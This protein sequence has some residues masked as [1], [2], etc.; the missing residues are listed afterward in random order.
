[1]TSELEE[2]CKGG[3][4]VSSHTPELDKALFRNSNKQVYPSLVQ[5][6]VQALVITPVSCQVKSP[7]VKVSPSLVLTLKQIGSHKAG[8]QS[9]TRKECHA[10]ARVT[11][12][13]CR[14]A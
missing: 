12:G 11:R 1:M 14:W 10:D 9:Q 13:C 6:L 4:Q 5:E 2:A 8:S 3:I 7:H